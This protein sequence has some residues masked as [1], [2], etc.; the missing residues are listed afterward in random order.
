[1][2][3]PSAP[4][5]GGGVTDGPPGGSQSGSGQGS[6]GSSGSSSS[7]SSSSNEH[8]SGKL[9]LT[10]SDLV[11]FIGANKAGTTSMEQYYEQ[12]GWNPCHN[13]CDGTL[14]WWRASFQHDTAD[15]IWTSHRVYMD[16]G[17]HADYQWLYENFPHSRF[18][19][20]VRPL[21][22][23]VLSRY[24]MVRQIR[25]NGGCSPQGT[26]ASCAQGWYGTPSDVETWTGNSDADI[27]S[28]IV[29]LAQVQE[30]QLEFFNKNPVR[31]N[32]FVM[33]DVTDSDN[34]DIT[35]RRL[36]WA[37]RKDLASYH[38][39]HLLKMNAELPGDLPSK[40]VSHLAGPHQVPHALGAPHPASSLRHVEE[41]L[42]AMGC[43]PTTWGKYIYDE[44]RT[45]IERSGLEL[46]ELPKTPFPS[47]RAPQPVKAEFY[48]AKGATSLSP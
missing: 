23:W 46:A 6:S 9:E 21:R 43:D 41:T 25:L 3:A 11:F 45:A 31:Q 48:K 4:S 47:S 17:D 28:W 42:L 39:D 33:L 22:D 14:E 12:L 19:M 27:R 1:M 37:Q 38:T 7:S 5:S 32:R 29:K 15:P 13:K 8:L 2:E 10:A 16:N 20:N 40:P 18:V 44:C 35:L 36:Y 24:D 30:R 34:E 26:T